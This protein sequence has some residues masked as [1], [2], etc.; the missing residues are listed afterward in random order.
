VSELRDHY[1][2]GFYPND[3]RD[4]GSW[5]KIRVKVKRPGV[6]VRTGAGYLDLE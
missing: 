5:H 3:P 4:D 6:K 2:L 1:V